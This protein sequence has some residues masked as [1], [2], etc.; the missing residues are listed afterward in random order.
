M[1]PT[2]PTGP[3]GAIRHAAAGLLV[4]LTAFFATAPFVD[5][6]PNGRYVDALLAT[7]VLAA[8]VAAIGTRTRPRVIASVLAAP[9]VY[10][11]WFQRHHTEGSPFII[12]VLLFMTFVGFVILHLLQFVRDARHVNSEVLCAAVAV[13]LLLGMLWA[14]AFTL[15]AR[16]VPGSF[17]GTAMESTPLQGFEALYF[18]LTT[19]TTA[20]FGDIAPTTAPARMLAM[21]EACTGT[22]YIAVLVAR[23]V[24]LYRAEAE[25]N[26]GGAT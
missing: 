22:L 10:A 3:P 9:L 4:A 17:A 23:L 7:G 11:Y 21:L 5:A 13:Y 26:P 1:A 19:L 6:L 2:R 24:S 25:A 12:F 14:A 20:G 8:A 15:T 18:S 16:L